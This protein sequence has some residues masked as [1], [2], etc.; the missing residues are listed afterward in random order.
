[1]TTIEIFYSNLGFNLKDL[2]HPISK[3]INELESKNELGKKLDEFF[4]KSLGLALVDIKE[5]DKKVYKI[6][7]QRIKTQP[8]SFFGHVFEIMQFQ[9]FVKV[10]KY[11]NLDLKFGNANKNEPD[12]FFNN[13]GFEVATR[14]LE[15]SLENEKPASKLLTTF[16][17]KNDKPYANE[18]TVLL[19]DM[20]NVSEKAIS[21]S[22]KMSL[23]EFNEI[24]EKETKFGCVIFFTEWIEEISMTRVLIASSV[25][26]SKTCN[27]DLKKMLENIFFHDNEFSKG[28]MIMLNN[29]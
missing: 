18:N 11:K 26:F 12:F 6:Y 21:K 19:I 17:E 7:L 3:I 28:K 16:N 1:M 9:H 23:I 25:V 5:F 24:I 22:V 10:S 15:V 14:R 2:S 27:A 13:F 8:D 4:L 20:T 29:K